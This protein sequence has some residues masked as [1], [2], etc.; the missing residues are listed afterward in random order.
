MVAWKYEISLLVLKK[1]FHSFATLTREIF[2]NTR[3][4]ISYVISSICIPV[5][6]IYFLLFLRHIVKPMRTTLSC[7]ETSRIYFTC[8]YF[9]VPT[10]A[11]QSLI[12]KQNLQS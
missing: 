8:V 12:S 10:L 1:I 6:Y 9:F 2:F 3:R 11:N 5:I 4:E 7:F